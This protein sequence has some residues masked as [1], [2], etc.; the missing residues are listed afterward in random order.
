VSRGFVAGA[1][2]QV[3]AEVL[4]EQGVEAE[5]SPHRLAA[6]RPVAVRLD[7]MAPLLGYALRTP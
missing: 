6:Q 4:E 2:A 3:V 7:R 1:A 5:Q